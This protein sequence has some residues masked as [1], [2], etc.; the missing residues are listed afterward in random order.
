[1]A[2][3]NAEILDTAAAVEK[4]KKIA[5]RRTVNRRKFM[6]ALGVAGAATGAGIVARKA[7]NPTAVEAAGPTQIDVLNF[8]LNIEYL[9]ATYYSY[10][11][12]G[13]DLPAAITTGSGPIYNFPA[14]I[15]FPTQQITDLMNELYFDEIGHVQALRS[16]LGSS[17]I[18]RPTLD[19]SG[20]NKTSGG[21]AT[22][23]AANA[24][25]LLRMFEDLGVT[26]YAGA[27]PLLS[28]SNLTYASQ[29][30]AVE[31]FHAG[32]L[33]LIAIQQS[34]P[35]NPTYSFTF[36][37]NTTSGSTSLTGATTLAFLQ[38]GQVIAGTGIP[39]GATVTS[40]DP[41]GLT[42]TISAAATATGSQVSL[43]SYDSMDVAPGDLGTATLASAG[44]ANIAG[45]TVQYTGFFATSGA[46]TATSVVPAGTAFARTTSQVLSALYATTFAAPN[47]GVFKGGFFPSGFNGI[48][49]TI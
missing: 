6:T 47:P 17:A 10:V 48:I 18:A 19:L 25:A 11:T 33:R 1:M 22:V 21:S 45:K 34:S 3:K 7:T 14:K 2:S 20:A 4:L 41:V 9:E 31:G 15:T 8:A 49:N 23:T 26:A 16:V 29:I 40:Y 5:S 24:I 39:V 35:Y 27:A 43:T 30:L 36:K 46:A 32:A 38:A 13:A 28:G 37:A 42:V 12:Q 44:P